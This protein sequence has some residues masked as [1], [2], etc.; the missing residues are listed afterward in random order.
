MISGFYNKLPKNPKWQASIL[1]CRMCNCFSL[2]T[3]VHSAK[4]TTS[5]DIKA[6][7][8]ENNKIYCKMDYNSKPSTRASRFLGPTCFIE[9]TLG[10][11]EHEAALFMG[12]K[13]IRNPQVLNFVGTAG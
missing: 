2:A 4:E 9:C 5:S 12:N 3:S 8:D 6:T 11:R 7:E 1:E 10:E 13:I